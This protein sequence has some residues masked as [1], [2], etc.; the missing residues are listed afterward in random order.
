MLVAE[1]LPSG[2][3]PNQALVSQKF[4]RVPTAIAFQATAAI[5]YSKSRAGER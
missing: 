1:F 5:I 4:Q 3:V 2:L